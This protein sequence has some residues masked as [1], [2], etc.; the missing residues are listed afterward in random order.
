MK[1]NY[2]IVLL[3]AICQHGSAMGIHLFP[4][5]LPSPP[6]PTVSI[7]TFDQNQNC[8]C[9]ENT[10]DGGAWWAAVHGISKSQTWLSD[11]TFTFHGLNSDLPWIWNV[12]WSDY[13]DVCFDIVF[14][15]YSNGVKNSETWK[16]MPQIDKII[17]STSLLC[18]YSLSL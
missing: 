2:N 3:S 11:F 4:P 14:L 9:L 6:P 16:L 17:C 7:A 13:Y 12:H 15:S 10:M 18:F 1:D 5:S 8:S